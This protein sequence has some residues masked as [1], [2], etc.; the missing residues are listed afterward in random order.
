MAKPAG[1]Q[2]SNTDF[3]QKKAISTFAHDLYLTILLDLLAKGD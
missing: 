2:F 3:L 1:N